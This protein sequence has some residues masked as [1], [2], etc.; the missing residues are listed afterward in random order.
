M[1]EPS[2]EIKYFLTFHGNEDIEDLKE[3]PVEGLNELAIYVTIGIGEVGSKSANDFNLMI[4]CGETQ[5]MK[6]AA[7]R[8]GRESVKYKR[9]FPAST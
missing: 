9:F 4:L 7:K 8:A 1:T 6:H 5:R 3:F 2:L